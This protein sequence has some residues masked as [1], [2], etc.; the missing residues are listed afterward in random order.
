MVLNEPLLPPHEALAARCGQRKSLN[1]GI[2]SLTEKHSTVEFSC[3]R[4]ERIRLYPLKNSSDSQIR[5]ELGMFLARKKIG[6]DLHGT[7][8]R[9]LDFFKKI[10]KML[11][12]ESWEVYIITGMEEEKALEEI[13]PYGLEYTGIL[14]VT[15]HHKNLGT[16]IEFDDNGNPWIEEKI[17][18]RTKADICWGMNICIHIDDSRSYGKFFGEETAYLQYVPCPLLEDHIETM[19]RTV[20]KAFLDKEKQEEEWT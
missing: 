8:D 3:Q 6:I 20:I 16:K 18:D 9:N 14:S 10:I 5:K 13:E 11:L 7:I 19:V 12:D 4:W 15:D 17:W 1:G 2:H